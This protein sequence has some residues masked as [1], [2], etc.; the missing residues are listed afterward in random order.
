MFGKSLDSSI[1]RKCIKYM[2][3]GNPGD[4]LQLQKKEKN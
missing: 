4:P 1:N 3:K 2:Y